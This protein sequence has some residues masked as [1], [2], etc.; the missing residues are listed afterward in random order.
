MELVAS[1]R[2]KAPKRVADF[3]RVLDDKAVDAVVV[4]TPDHWHGPLTAFDCQAG[5]D[6]YV[7]KPASHNV[8]E[9]RQMVEAASADARSAST[10][11]PNRLSATMRP[12]SCSSARTALHS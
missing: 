4:A 9:G 10:R 11:K 3:R 6:V 12:T 5:K 7:K 2:G 1:S 8:W